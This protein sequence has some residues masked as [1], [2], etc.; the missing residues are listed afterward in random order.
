M[1]DAEIYT[2]NSIAIFPRQ[3]TL[4]AMKHMLIRQRRAFGK[5]NAD[6]DIIMRKGRKI[7]GVYR[8]VG[9]DLVRQPYTPFF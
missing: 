7:H 3:P 9:D 6:T 1:Y 8:L 2:G 5:I 4:G